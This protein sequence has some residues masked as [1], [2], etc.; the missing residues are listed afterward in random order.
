MSEKEPGETQQVAPAEES[1]ESQ[2]G[3]ESVPEP[4]EMSDEAKKS[5]EGKTPEE[6]A[7]M[8]H[9]L[10]KKLGTQGAELGEQKNLNESLKSLVEEIRAGREQQAQPNPFQPAYEQPQEVAPQVSPE[11]KLADDDYLT[12]GAVRKIMSQRDDESKAQRMTELVQKTSIAFEKGRKS[13]SGRLYDGIENEVAQRVAQSYIMP[14]KTFGMDVSDELQNPARWHEAAVYLRAQRGEYDRITP[15]KTN[16][17][18]ATQT[19][20]PSS[21]R[22]SPSSTPPVDINTSD[23]D[24]QIFMDEMENATGKRP[25]KK[26][27]EEIVERGAQVTYGDVSMSDVNKG[28]R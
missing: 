18:A 8:H 11:E 7:Q 20:T 12:V 24:M 28:N 14:F 25:T 10:S 3:S 4:E 9:D 15:E 6:L 22:P 19:E 26:E 5:Y 17:M 1:Q 27:M 2:Q 13:M 21:V 16:P 23:R